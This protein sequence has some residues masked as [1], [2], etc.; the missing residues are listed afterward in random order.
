MY[1]STLDFW[2]A[3]LKIKFKNKYINPIQFF[4]NQDKFKIINE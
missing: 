3:I 1:V 4:N 2:I